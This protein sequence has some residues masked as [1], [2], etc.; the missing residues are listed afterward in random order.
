[1]TNAKNL[2]I[3]LVGETWIVQKFHTKGFDMIPLGGYEDFSQWFR[4]ALS[5]Y[6]DLDLT[7]IP[8][9]LVLSEFPKTPED[10][11]K[12]DVIVLSDVGRNTLSLYPEMFKVPMGPDKL[13]SVKKF[14]ESGGGLVM[15]GGWMSFQGYQGRASYHGTPIEDVLPVKISEWDDRVEV[16]EG[17]APDILKENHP[18]LSDIPSKDWPKFLGYNRL[19][20]K[21]DATVIAK[22]G[23]DPFIVVNSYGKGRTMAFASDLAPHWGTDFVKWEFY[24]KFWHN[25]LRWLA[26][27]V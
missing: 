14:V 15:S 3:L 20:A 13:K 22:F 18:I 12:F 10:M 4:D 7:H 16:T 26:G 21:E 9:H 1:M 11:E 27:E 23:V 25:S 8:N 17:I 5:K 24:P 19:E 2:N 6:S